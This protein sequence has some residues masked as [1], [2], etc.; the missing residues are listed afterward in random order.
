MSKLEKNKDTGYNLF[1][2]ENHKFSHD[3]KKIRILDEYLKSS[4][5]FI[6]SCF[7][8]QDPQGHPNIKAQNTHHVYRGWIQNNFQLDNYL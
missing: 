8:S 3:K 6:I 5:D 7:L 1:K 2:F 4:S